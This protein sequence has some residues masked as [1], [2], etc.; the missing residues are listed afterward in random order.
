MQFIFFL[1]GMYI[2]QEFK[3]IPNIKNTV[4]LLYDMYNNINK[5]K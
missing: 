1:L 5:N 4:M 3:E 2:G